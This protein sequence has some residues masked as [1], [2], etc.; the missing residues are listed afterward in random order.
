MA[1]GNWREPHCGPLVRKLYD[2]YRESGR[3]LLDVAGRTG[4]KD[5]TIRLW[6]R[7]A[8]DPR[9]SYFEAALNALGHRIEIVPM[10]RRP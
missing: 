7:S 1:R 4:V 6:F 5:E 3:S 8:K 2:L 9:L 10:E